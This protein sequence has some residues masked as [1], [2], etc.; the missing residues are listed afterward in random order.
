MGWEVEGGGW[1]GRWRGGGV[2]VVV[3]RVVVEM[4][5][6]ERGEGKGRE[7]ER[8]EKGVSQEKNDLINKSYPKKSSQKIKKL[9]DFPFPTPHNSHN[10]NLSPS[11]AMKI[12]FPSSQTVRQFIL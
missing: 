9:K 6:W 2:G 10:R 4:M 7:R 8:E 5:G 1:V 12:I 3:E 11:N